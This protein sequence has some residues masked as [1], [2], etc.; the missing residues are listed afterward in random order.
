MKSRVFAVFAIL[1]A[2]ASSARAQDAQYWTQQFGNQARL[3]GGA[4]VGGPSDLSATY[5]NPG[6]LALLTDPDLLLAGNVFE[7]TSLRLK[8]AVDNET[9][10]SNRVAPVPSLFAGEFGGSGPG[11]SR[12]AY[13]FLSRH[14]SNFRID[15][16]RELSGFTEDGA[17]L[18]TS[19]YSLDE[20]MVEFWTGLTWARRLGHGVGFGISGYVTIRDRR[21]RDLLLAQIAIGSVAGVALER[22]DFESVNV[23]MLAKVG[24]SADLH[25]WHLGM[26]ATTP[27]LPLYGAGSVGYDASFVAGDIDGNGAPAAEITSAFQDGV[28]AAQRSPA[29]L[30]LGASRTLGATTVHVATEWFAA[31]PGYTLLDAQPVTSADGSTTY[32]IKLRDARQSVINVALGIEHRLNDDV[33]GYL[34]CRTDQSAADSDDPARTAIGVW[35]IYHLTGGVSFRALGSEFTVGLM[36]AF[37]NETIRARR[38]VESAIDPQLTDP[39]VD[40]L[41]V[42]FRRLTGLVGFVFGI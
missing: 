24:L 1:I 18:A 12:F 39:A 35:D 34:G 23:G 40:N 42:R 7:Y 25:G 38:S 32:D 9:F 28:D 13:S 21:S 6:R 16:R 11:S 19:R 27:K 17:D 10:Q 41:E 26:T 31:V 30:A 22:Y 4:V 14:A 2:I 20:S 3:L 36:Y 5:Y 37:G 8:G 15:E 29:S 33:R